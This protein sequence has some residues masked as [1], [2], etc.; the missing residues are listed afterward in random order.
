MLSLSGAVDPVV[1]KADLIKWWDALDAITGKFVDQDIA[2]GLQLARSCAHPDAQWL[3]SLFPEGDVEVTTWDVYGTMKA[4]GRDP[5]A[6]HVGALVSAFEL[7]VNEP[8]SLGYAPAE[9]A[10]SFAAARSGRK[11]EALMWANKANA[12]GVSR[13]GMFCLAECYERQCVP[14]RQQGGLAQE[15]R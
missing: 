15:S 1:D 12:Q 8:A 14:R 3:S 6:L 13:H 4:Q 7:D 9:A 11:A 2:Q 5:R 10:M